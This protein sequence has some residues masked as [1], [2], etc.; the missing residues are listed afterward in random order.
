V[1]DFANDPAAVFVDDQKRAGDIYVT[2][3]EL[4]HKV[5]LAG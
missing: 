2:A 3:S 5:L 4:M 1:L